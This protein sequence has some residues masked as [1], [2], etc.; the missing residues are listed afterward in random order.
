MVVFRDVEMAAAAI[1]GSTAVSR[2]DARKD[3]W[4]V[5]K[6][7]GRRRAQ[8][9]LDLHLGLRGHGHSYEQF[10]HDPP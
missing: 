6:N 4:G 10:I 9:L 1:R 7:F 8:S 5:R 3:G 2:A